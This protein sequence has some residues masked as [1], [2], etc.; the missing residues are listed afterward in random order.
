M[1]FSFLPLGAVVELD[2]VFSQPVVSS[3]VNT[4]A[5]GKANHSVLVLYCIICM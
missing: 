2:G 5:I 4:T 3:A 1:N